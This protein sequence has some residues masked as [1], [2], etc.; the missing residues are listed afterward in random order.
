M[1]VCSS[2]TPATTASYSNAR[3][4]QADRLRLFWHPRAIGLAEDGVGRLANC[5]PRFPTIR[6]RLNLLGLPPR[7]PDTVAPVRRHGRRPALVEEPTWRRGGDPPRPAP[8]RDAHQPL[9]SLAVG[10]GE[11]DRSG[12]HD[13][14]VGLGAF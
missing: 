8:R 3:R 9:E 5:P 1:T 2:V 13:A 7:P 4:R 14:H 10:A 6:P 12:L 11:A